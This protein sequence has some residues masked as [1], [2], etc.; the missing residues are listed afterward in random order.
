MSVKAEILDLLGK[1]ADTEG[2]Q[3]YD[4]SIALVW[5]DEDMGVL[6][7]KKLKRKVL[8]SVKDEEQSYLTDESFNL[9]FYQHDRVLSR[10]LAHV[11]ERLGAEYQNYLA[12]FKPEIK[13][14]LFNDENEA[15]AE[16]EDS[17]IV[18][19]KESEEEAWEL[20]RDPGL[21]YKFGKALEK[22]VHLDDIDKK[23]FIIGEEALKRDLVIK[24]AEGMMGKNNINIIHGTY[25][26]AKDSML[27]TIFKITGATVMERG[28]ITAAGMRY[29]KDL[30]DRD[31]LYLPEADLE[32]EKARQ[33]RFMRPG[34]G[35]FFVEY[36]FK[37]PETGIMETKNERVNATSIFITTNATSFDPA[38]ASGAWIY[39]TDESQ[40]LTEE[41][42]K[43]KLL[44]AA[45]PHETLTEEELNIWQC[46]FNI[47]T[48]NDDI[49][50]KITVPYAAELFSFFN[51]TRTDARRSPDKMLD[52][53]R[54]VAILRRYQKPEENRDTADVVDLFTALRVGGSAIEETIEDLTHREREIYKIV[55]ENKAPENEIGED[56]G[57]TAKDISFYSELAGDRCYR[58]AESLAKKGYFFQNR[59][60]RSH[61]YTIKMKYDAK[62]GLSRLQSLNSPKAVLEACVD[63]VKGF[64]N[65][66]NSLG[67][68]R[69][70]C[71]KVIEDHQ[72]DNINS[73]E[74]TP[75]SLPVFFSM[76]LTQSNTKVIDPLT[77]E[78]YYIYCTEGTNEINELKNG[79][80]KSEECLKTDTDKSKPGYR[81]AQSLEGSVEKGDKNKKPLSIESWT[82]INADSITDPNSKQP[83]ELE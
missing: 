25:A 77:G 23:R 31:I 39:P 7:Y 63:K 78:S 14:L 66:L 46:A 55:D 67:G 74:N 22:G 28:Y 43:Q 61:R 51:T 59:L 13:N 17:P 60:G 52:L 27:K 6:K 64:L 21:F 34:D 65:S 12:V 32:G 49:P 36:A 73:L 68:L 45:A 53:I 8:I 16:E 44:D 70:I 72:K 11:K 10:V 19:S 1:I 80:S 24:V 37:N 20:V 15:T 30:G 47:L 29:S 9:D 2:A 3:R 57:F 71:I 35:G 5:K 81:D 83:E 26:T 42:I 48:R 69:D 56:V 79:L 4:D 41:V 58:Y 38:I 33:M 76:G 50:D 62:V 54:T 18:F 82:D 75:L 40:E